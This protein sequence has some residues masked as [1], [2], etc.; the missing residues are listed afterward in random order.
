MRI[1]LRTWLVAALFGLCWFQP[2]SAAVVLFDDFGTTGAEGNWPGDSFFQSIPQPGNVSGLPSI[3]LVGPGFFQQLA[4]QGNSVDL[5]GTTGNGNN[6][7]GQLSSIQSFVLG[8]YTISFLLAGNLRGASAQTTVVSF[9]NQFFSFTPTNT[10]PY[11][12]QT[13][14]FTGV[15]GVLSFADLG[16]SNQQGNLLDNITVTTGVPEPSTWVMMLLGFAAL[17]FAGFRKSR[18]PSFQ[19]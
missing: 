15:S 8:D 19:L 1:L 18:R 11:T 12:L 5:D 4:Y 2:A 6:P 14:H 3:D 16:P 17:A 9:G 7:A 13:V 10:Q